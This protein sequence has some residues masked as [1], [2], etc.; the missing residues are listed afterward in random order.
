[1]ANVGHQRQHRQGLQAH[2][3]LAWVDHG[4]AQPRAF[5]FPFTASSD[6]QPVSG[7]A[8]GDEILAPAQAQVIEPGLHVCRPHAAL[9]SGTQC[10]QARRGAGPE[11]AQGG[12]VADQKSQARGG[13]GPA[14]EHGQFER[15]H[16]PQLL[17]QRGIGIGQ[18]RRNRKAFKMIE[19]F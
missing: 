10:A 9:F 2:T 16:R 14:A 1:M 5:T 3:G 15:R 4:Q 18:V 6:Q 19:A 13:H 8:G 12:L 11:H 7:I 17:Q